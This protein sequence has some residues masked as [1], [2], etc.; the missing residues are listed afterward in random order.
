MLSDQV[1]ILTERILRLFFNL[2]QKILF[3]LVGG[4]NTAFSIILYYLLYNLISGYMGYLSVLVLTHI[5]SVL[6][7]YLALK[8]FVFRTE[9]HYIREFLRCN[10]TYLVFLIL[11]FS[12]LYIS[13]D[14]LEIAPVVAQTVI[15]IVMAILSYIGHKYFSFARK[16]IS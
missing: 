9:G 2:P 5:L 12:L 16:Q 6:N 10:I 4:Y 14:L 13:V 3:I 8:W 15:V 7:S 1:A 11:N